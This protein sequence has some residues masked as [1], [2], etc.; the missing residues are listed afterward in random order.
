[1]ESRDVNVRAVTRFGA[2]IVGG[3]IV[4]VFLMWF[5]FDRL[6]SRATRLSPRPETMAAR[7]P[8]KEPPEPQLQRAPAMDLKEFQAG[9]EAVLNNYGWVDA[10]KGIVRIPVERA[11]KLVEQEGLPARKEGGTQ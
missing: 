1:M 9:E 10:E 4:V 11:M 7:N 5:L 6:A 3:V 2:G 8:Q